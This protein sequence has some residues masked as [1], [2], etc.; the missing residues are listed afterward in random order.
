MFI[1]GNL[2]EVASVNSNTSITL[3]TPTVAAA[4]AAAYIIIPIFASEAQAPSALYDLVQQIITRYGA[5]LNITS[6]DLKEMLLQKGSS[7]GINRVRYALAGYG[8]LFDHGT[9]SDNEFRLRS[10]ADGSTPVTAMSV[11]RATGIVSFPAGVSNVWTDA[12]LPTRLQ[13]YLTA[14]STSTYANASLLREAAWLNGSASPAGYGAGVFENFPANNTTAQI[15]RFIDGNGNCLWRARVD[16]SNYTAWYPDNILSGVYAANSLAGAAQSFGRMYQRYA[17]G[18]EISATNTGG[19]ANIFVEMYPSSGASGTYSMFRYSTIAGVCYLNISKGDG[20]GS[21]S[22]RVSGGV[23]DSFSN[24]Q[25]GNLIIG[26]SGQPGNFKCAIGGS[27]GFTAHNAYDIGSAAQRVANI[28]LSNAPNVGSDRRMKKNISGS[29]LGLTF[30]NLLKPS[31]YQ[32]ITGESIIESVE[33][34]LEKEEYDTGEVDADGVPIFALRPTY[35]RQTKVVENRAGRRVHYGLIAQEVKESLDAVGCDDFAGYVKNDFNDPESL[36]SLRYEQFI[37]PLIKAVQEL[38]A[39]VDAQAAQIE[40][41]Q[42]LL[43]D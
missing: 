18:L 3:V 14:T 6:A 13:G 38:S 20:T 27:L 2:Y 11:A 8:D 21:T 22:A 43:N 10:F 7:S 34:E 40:E 12:N 15:Q 5:V 42:A 16:A 29:D 1:G 31:R 9:I 37:A 24:V 19:N 28:Y 26:A 41:L 4:S 39:K 30:I 33:Q 17:T 32:L 35:G 23:G 36:L 25:G